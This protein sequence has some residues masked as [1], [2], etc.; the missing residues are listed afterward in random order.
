VCFIYVLSFLLPCL[1]QC[2]RLMSQNKDLLTYLL[3]YSLCWHFTRLMRLQN[4]YPYR[5]P[6]CTLYILYK[7]FVNFSAVNHSGVLVSLQ[8][9]GGCTH[10]KNMHVCVVSNRL[11]RLIFTKFSAN[12]ER[13]L[14]FITTYSNCDSSIKGCWL[15]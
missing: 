15:L 4:L 2:S 11:Y 8:K 12:V 9:V 3:T 5:D 1:I 13:L 10:A 14:C 7:N 6:G